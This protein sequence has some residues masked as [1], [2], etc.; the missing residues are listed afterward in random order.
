MKQK[1]NIAI[2]LFLLLSSY[3]YACTNKM[4]LGAA[5]EEL[6]FLIDLTTATH[7]PILYS[8][9]FEEVEYVKLETTPECL[10]E[11]GMSHIYLTDKYIIFFY[12]KQQNA[13]LFDRKTGRFIKQIGRRG[14]GPNEYNGFVV[15]IFDE[16]E[17]MLYF[18]REKE[19]KEWIGYHIE[20]DN[21]S[22]IKQ[23][24]TFKRSLSGNNIVFSSIKNFIK[25]DSIATPKR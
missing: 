13:Y 6:P 21:S 14:Q 10:I 18:E 4:T 15:P 19:G 16:N 24:V 25:I 2:L 8:D 12:I 23:P 17:S 22:I 9:V 20:T 7:K 5:D 11:S 3:L 1:N